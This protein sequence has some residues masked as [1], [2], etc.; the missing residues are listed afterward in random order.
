[1]DV[2][3][4]ATAVALLAVGLASAVL[5]AA[6]ALFVVRTVPTLAPASGAK[7][8]VAAAP[9]GGAGGV[10]RLL[11]VGDSVV[12]GTGIV[13]THVD[14]FTGHVARA[15]AASQGAEVR[16][17][18][19]GR[20][21]STASTVRT[22]LMEQAVAA[23]D[24]LGGPVDV[25]ALSVGVNDAIR[26]STTFEFKQSLRALLTDLRALCPDATIVLSA[27]PP[28]RLFP[29]LPF[30][31]SL[32]LGWRASRVFGAGAE[33]TRDT[34]GAA[35]AGDLSAEVARAGGAPAELF[36]ADGFHP[37]PRILAVLG[38]AIAARYAEA[39]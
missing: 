39:A 23:R 36:L 7:H 10:L 38:G 13:G 20:A 11:A 3:L 2:S 30:P 17:A 24:S 19:A 25:L 15:L 29:A 34:P 5:V 6:Q 1:M 27:E 35:Y 37:G 9:S 4:A 21:G 8:G 31:L 33:V 32:V 12:E 18:C 28:V 14:A 22:G 26:G 16:W